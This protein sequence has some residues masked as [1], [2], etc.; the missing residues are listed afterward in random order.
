MQASRCFSFSSEGDA[1]SQAEI[2]PSTASSRTRNP[3]NSTHIRCADSKGKFD[4]V[5][6]DN[7][8][9]IIIEPTAIMHVLGTT[10]DFVEDR[11]RCAVLPQTLCS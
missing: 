11:I 5:V 3:S 1:I 6:E 4:E 10:M 9:R 8:V 7:G 2:P